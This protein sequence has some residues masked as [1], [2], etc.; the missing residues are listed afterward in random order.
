[1]RYMP[2]I[3]PEKSEAA[4]VAWREA[5]ERHTAERDRLVRQAEAAGITINRI[6]VLTG[7]ARTTIYRILGRSPANGHGRPARKAQPARKSKR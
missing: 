5:H 6:Y 4:L 2:K 1:M 3:G 7:I